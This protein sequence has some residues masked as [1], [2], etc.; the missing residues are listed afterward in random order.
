[1][2]EV[3]DGAFAAVL[4]F[5]VIARSSVFEVVA[6]LDILKDATAI[7]M[8]LHERFYGAAVELSRILFVMVRKLGAAA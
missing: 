8:M 7:E 2:I 1:M 5:F 3:A 6:I 4:V